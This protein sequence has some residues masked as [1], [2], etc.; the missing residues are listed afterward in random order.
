M[1]IKIQKIEYVPS[2]EEISENR[3][4]LKRLTP[5]PGEIINLSDGTTYKVQ[6]SGQFKRLTRRGGKKS[7]RS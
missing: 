1:S 3:K 4:K 2:K 6:E 7:R 5:Q